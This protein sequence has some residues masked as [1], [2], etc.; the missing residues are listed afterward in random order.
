MEPRASYIAVGAFVIVLL[1]GLM[2]FITWLTQT[3]LDEVRQ[4]YLIYFTQSVTGLQIGSAVRYRGVSVGTVQDIRIDPDNVE[5]IEVRVTIPAD[6]PIKEDTVASLELLGLT[7]QAFVN[8]TGG[9]QAAEPLRA[10]SGE[11]LP[12]IPSQP[13]TIDELLTSAPELLERL[14]NLTSAAE[15]LLGTE[16]RAAVAEILASLAAFSNELEG[17]G[18]ELDT[19]LRSLA[20]I[21]S[22]A[23]DLMI[24][25]EDELLIVSDSLQQTA[26]A[27]QN[28]LRT[29]DGAAVELRGLLG[30]NREPL[31]DFT[32]QALYDFGLLLSEL[33]GLA[34][35]LNALTSRLERSPG[36]ILR[37]ASGGVEPQ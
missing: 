14:I 18:A 25:A 29:I 32:S 12:I 1:V 17:A 37:G 31:R 9:S 3:Q 36:D 15:E 34:A 30:E 5:K 26:L 8:L 2:G 33:R 7:G 4:P 13:S 21:S 22:Q 16:N 10:R 23:D 19:T 28:T 6:V 11:G 20:S 27:A 35:N 24:T